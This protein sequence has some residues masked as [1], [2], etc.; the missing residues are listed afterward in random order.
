MEFQ[1]VIEQFMWG[2]Q[3]HYYIGLKSF[4]ERFFNGILPNVFNQVFLLGVLLPDETDR[5]AVCIQQEEDE[6]KQNDFKDV[7]KLA[8]EL[9]QVSPGNKIFQSHPIAQQHHRQRVEMGT[10]Q[11]AIKKCIEQKSIFEDLL[12]YVSS[13]VI[14]GKYNVF[15]ILQLNHKVYNSFYKLTND[16]YYRL[17]IPLS[18][19][20][21][22]IP[23]FFREARKCL[24]D[25]NSDG[26]DFAEIDEKNLRKNAGNNF[27]YSVSCKGD[28]G[29][30]GFGLFDSIN[31]ISSL[32][33]ESEDAFG[34]IIIAR[35]NHP[36][37]HLDIEFNEAFSIRKPRLIRKLLELTSNH[38]SLICDSGVVYGIGKIIGEYNPVNEDLFKIVITGHYQW[39]LYHDEKKLLQASYGFPYIPSSVFSQEEFEARTKRIFPD[40]EQKKLFELYHC[41]NKLV[42]EHKGGILVITDHAR[43]ESKRLCKQSIGISPLVLN[44][45]NITKLSS[46]DGAIIIDIN[47]VCYSIGTILDGEA[48]E[49]GNPERGSRYNS[50]L[51]YCDDRRLKGEKVVIVVISEDG[52]V[53]IMPKLNPIMKKSE[54][55]KAVEDYLAISLEENLTIKRFYQLTNAISLLNFYLNKEQCTSINK[56]RK[57][58]ENFLWNGKYK[59]YPKC[60]YQDLIPNDKFDDSYLE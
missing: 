59:E 21:S 14:I 19:I 4:A 25:I 42:L 34:S 13:P 58:I 31:N 46:I 2:Y 11:E 41:V 35:K 16:T 43:E 54:I 49:N 60:I 50:S 5:N 22:S 52:M 8:K 9:L 1:N 15:I 24:R 37:I 55:E 10:F 53:D 51:R 7:E 45:E 20:D 30:G 47:C 28:S 12:T 6:Y 56:K 32:K 33:Y 48:N 3:Q 27:F 23:L 18:I 39:T 36:N 38:M 26:M 29:D 17:F 57:E 44:T 40:L